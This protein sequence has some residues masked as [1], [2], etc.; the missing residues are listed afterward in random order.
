MTL[1]HNLTNGQKIKRYSVRTRIL[2]CSCNLKRFSAIN[3]K[4]GKNE[5][6][7]CDALTLAPLLFRAA[8]CHL[9]DSNC[10]YFA[11]QETLCL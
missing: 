8:D 3:S 11:T 5:E 10:I 6:H 1:G 2:G 7:L 4:K 9:A